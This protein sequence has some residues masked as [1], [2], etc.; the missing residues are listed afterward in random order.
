MTPC[1]SERNVK[2]TLA[3]H[4]GWEVLLQ[5]PLASIIFHSLRNSPSGMETMT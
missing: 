3:D 5:P 4:L 2:D 1:F